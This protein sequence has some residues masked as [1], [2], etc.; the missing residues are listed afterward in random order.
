MVSLYFLARKISK[1]NPFEEFRNGSQIAS[2]QAVV[3]SLSLVALTVIP[4]P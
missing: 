1:R 2:E 4:T 3:W